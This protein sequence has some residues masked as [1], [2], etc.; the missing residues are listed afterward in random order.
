MRRLLAATSL[1]LIS[2]ADGAT[3]PPDLEAFRGLCEPF[4]ACDCDA[5]RYRDVDACMAEQHA[6]FAQYH[7]MAAATGLHAD[8]EC[9]LDREQ[10]D[11]KDCLGSTDYHAQH[12]EEPPPR[13][14][15][16]CGVCQTVF[17]DKQP[18]AACLQ[19]DYAASDCAQGLL[20]L[21]DP[22][23]CVDPC[24]PTPIGER[25][26][27]NASTCGPG[28]FCETH[29]EPD[30]D[31]DAD[32]EVCRALAGP[33]EPC[34]WRSCME[35]LI[36]HQEDDVCVP[37]GAVDER[38]E[39]IDCQP[40]LECVFFVEPD[41]H[42]LQSWKCRPPGDEGEP[43][44]VS[45]KDGLYCQSLKKRCTRWSERGEPCDDL[46]ACA[47]GLICASG[48]CQPSPGLGEPCVGTCEIGLDCVEGA[49]EHEK[50]LACFR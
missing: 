47:A 33:G 11:T 12:P 9:Y 18:G 44:D 25:C 37:A 21:G 24:A 43:C 35:G 27:S 40:G 34:S 46:H 26:Y 50:P 28:R 2:C 31:C 17:G 36:C 15:S 23:V 4:F 1:L 6:G 16:R 10:T 3:T 14:L 45:C 49:C 19:L 38:C 20:C 13:E 41:E 42:G 32:E 22:G 48:T 39:D 5:Y 30:R 8:L 29:C 7:G